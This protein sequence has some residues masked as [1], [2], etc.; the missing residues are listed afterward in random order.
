MFLNKLAVK[1]IKA[2]QKNKDIIGRGK[3]RFIPSCS[4]YAIE[5]YKKFNFLKAS[6]LTGWRI[7]RCNP[8]SKG[9]YN[10]VPLNRKEKKAKKEN[11][12]NDK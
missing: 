2:Y 12:P 11:K 6:F 7:L 1:A 9:G 4:N 5:C 10:P 3:C 8:L